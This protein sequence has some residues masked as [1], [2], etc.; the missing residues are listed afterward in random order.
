MEASVATPRVIE[1]D[2]GRRFPSLSELWMHRDLVYYL[3]RREVMGRYQQSVVG[4]FW[5]ILQPL[6]LATVFSVF[7]GLL[8]KVPSQPGVPYPVFA[9]SGMVLWMFISGALS[10]ASE[11]TVANEV[12]ISKVYFPRVIIPL[13]SM[14]PAV[15]DFGF[16]FLV[17]IGAM[18]VYG[19]GFHLQI[20]LM[21]L[22]F[23]LAAATVFGAA[24]WL[25][26]LN[27]RYRDVNQVMPFLILVGMFI[28]PIA[29]PFNLVPDNLQPVY[30]LNPVVGLVEASR[31]TLFGSSDLTLFVLLVPVVA[32]AVLLVTGAAYFQRAERSFADV[33]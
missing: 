29:Y 12:L 7:F 19:V 16:A 20:L 28:S 22:V 31:W 24:L 30:A 23:L 14:F 21:P 8:A 5:A 25:S 1:P 15:I 2:S 3:A 26:A 10:S 33:I 17:V 27:V 4:V 9:V 32:A 11:S 18:L 6:L 13:T